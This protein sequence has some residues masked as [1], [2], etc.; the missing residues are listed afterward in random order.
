MNGCEAMSFLV[1]ALTFIT[2]FLF[3]LMQLWPGFNQQSPL[4]LTYTHGELNEMN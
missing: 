1:C 4:T 2:F 3:T